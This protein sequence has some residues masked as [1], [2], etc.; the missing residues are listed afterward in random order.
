MMSV[1]RGCPNFIYVA[2]SSEGWPEAEVFVLDLGLRGGLC[3]VASL[4]SRTSKTMNGFGSEVEISGR[5]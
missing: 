2:D 3:G 1:D 4:R 5:C